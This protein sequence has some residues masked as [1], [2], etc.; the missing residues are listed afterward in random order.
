MWIDLGDVGDR[1]KKDRPEAVSSKRSHPVLAGL[2]TLA[3]PA[4]RAGPTLTVL[5]VESGDLVSRGKTLPKAGKLFPGQQ[6]L[7][8]DECRLGALDRWGSPAAHGDPTDDG[9]QC[10]P[11]L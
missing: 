7:K 3:V 4:R 6:S 9:R 8:V 11:T 5:V 1:T 2:I 10:P